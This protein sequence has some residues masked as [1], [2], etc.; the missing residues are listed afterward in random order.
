METECMYEG[1]LYKASLDDSNPNEVYLK[2]DQNDKEIHHIKLDGF[3]PGALMYLTFT[4]NNLFIINSCHSIFSKNMFVIPKSEL[5]RADFEIAKYG[6]LSKCPRYE[7]VLV[8][9]WIAN[10]SVLLVNFNSAGKREIFLI[11]DINQINDSAFFGRYKDAE[12]KN[13]LKYGRDPEQDKAPSSYEV[14]V[15]DGYKLTIT[16]NDSEIVSRLYP[17]QQG[18]RRKTRK[19]RGR[20]PATRKK[21]TRK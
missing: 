17:N 21:S 12:D 13:T 5:F 14:D 7:T 6:K 4:E 3:K 10:D 15:M 20:R 8:V 11:K 19:Q 1:I 18:G 16:Y 2:V 9:R